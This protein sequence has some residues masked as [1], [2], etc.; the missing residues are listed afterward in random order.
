MTNPQRMRATPVDP[1]D[2][3]GEIENTVYRVYFIESGGRTDE[4]RLQYCA[5]VNEALAWA[6]QRD[7]PFDFYA[8]YPVVNGLALL[9]LAHAY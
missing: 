4:W 8:E 5:D 9:H 6:R 2:I 3:L 1:R 7:I